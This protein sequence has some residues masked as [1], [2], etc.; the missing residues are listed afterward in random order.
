VIR[1][2]RSNGGGLLIAV[3]AALAEP[4][5]TVT[6]RVTELKSGGY[7]GWWRIDF[8]GECLGDMPLNVTDPYETKEEA[9]EAVTSIVGAMIVRGK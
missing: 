8:D 3:P 4:E 2:N 6:V 1:G 5:K 7:Y 9:E